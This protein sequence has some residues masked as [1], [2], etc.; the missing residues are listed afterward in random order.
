MFDWKAGRLKGEKKQVM[1]ARI[2]PDNIWM[3]RFMLNG[4][5]DRVHVALQRYLINY[6]TKRSPLFGVVRQGSFVA[7]K[8]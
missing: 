3:V 8:S 1:G 7:K 2:T 5:P 6:G 4:N